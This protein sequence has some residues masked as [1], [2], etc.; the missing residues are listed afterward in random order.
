M[1]LG[2]SA[3][4]STSG[5]K[6]A[7]VHSSPGQAIL[8]L[9][10]PLRNPT[11]M[12]APNNA[13]A[14]RKDGRVP[15]FPGANCAHSTVARCANSFPPTVSTARRVGEV[16]HGITT[17]AALRGTHAERPHPDIDDDFPPVPAQKSLLPEPNFLFVCVYRSPCAASLGTPCFAVQSNHVCSIVLHWAEARHAISL[18]SE[19]PGGMGSPIS[20]HLDSTLNVLDPHSS[21]VIRCRPDNWHDSVSISSLRMAHAQDVPFPSRLSA[22]WDLAQPASQRWPKTHPGA[23]ARRC[24]HHAF[25]YA[26]KW[27]DCDPLYKSPPPTDS[28]PGPLCAE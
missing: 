21:I 26:V 24:I 13:V 20:G 12:G 9:L 6:S 27:C 3:V 5:S 7:H 25:Q 4:G 15:S 18:L 11:A 19:M 22:C 23:V 16:A 1:P 10:L 14:L 17:S 8:L 28:P 2:S